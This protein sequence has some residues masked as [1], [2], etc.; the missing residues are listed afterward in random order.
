MASGHH[1]WRRRCASVLAASLV[2][3]TAR[4]EDAPDSVRLALPPWSPIPVQPW[5][6]SLHVQEGE[7][8]LHFAP[9][10]SAPRRG[11]VAEGGSLPAFAAQLGTGCRSAWFQVGPEA[12]LCSDVVAFSTRP[13]SPWFLQTAPSG[14][15]LPFRYYFAGP[16]GARGYRNLL[17]FDVA[18][19]AF[20]FDEGF[21]IAVVQERIVQ[22]ERYARTRRGLWVR[23][24]EFVPARPSTFRGSELTE[25]ERDLSFAWVVVDRAPLYRRVGSTFVPTGHAKARFERVGWFEEV[26]TPFSAY[27]RIDAEVWIRSSDVRHPTRAEPPADERIARGSRWLDIDLASQTLVAYEGDR[28]RFA[29]LVST[30]RGK[31][32]SPLSTPLGLHRIWVK[33]LAT[34]MDNLEDESASSYYRIED[35]PYVQFFAKGV[36]IHAAFWHRSFGHVRSHGCVNVAP[37]DAAFLFAF[38]GPVVPSGWSAALPTRLD[39]GTPVRVR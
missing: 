14:D 13:A 19:P 21:A 32:G 6:S 30:G 11:S 27:A 31:E 34:T 18:E 2:V 4:A 25:A 23:L 5:P 33:L 15:G 37:S 26:R 29:T 20:E 7:Q 8:S 9:T 3:G 36:G 39:G 22:G 17:E 1:R 38:T 24:A 10:S 28:P 35:V 16:S 12:W